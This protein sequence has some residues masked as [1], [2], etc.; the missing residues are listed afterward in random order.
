MSSMN[1]YL[2]THHKN[3]KNKSVL[4][5]MWV[6]K[7]FVVEIDEKYFEQKK[8]ANGNVNNRGRHTTKKD[9]SVL[10]RNIPKS[11]TDVDC[12]INS[13]FAEVKN[14][15][16]INKHSSTPPPRYLMEHTL[17]KWGTRPTEVV[18]LY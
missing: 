1:R 16:A 13:F 5:K 11:L 4:T 7:M 3:M 6:E 9:I 18:R 15:F 17:P 12:Q 8:L 10:Q 2:G 14:K